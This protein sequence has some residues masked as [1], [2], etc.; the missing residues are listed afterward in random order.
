MDRERGSFALQEIN[1]MRI[2]FFPEV[3]WQQCTNSGIFE[4][5]LE[6]FCILKAI[7]NTDLGA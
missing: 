4:K 2:F 5:K 7:E 3:S 1:I 6:M